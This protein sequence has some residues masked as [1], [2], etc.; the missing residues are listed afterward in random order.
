MQASLKKYFPIFVLPT[1]IAFSIAFVVPFIIG[2][3]LS[4]T[5][6]TTVTDAEFNGVQNYVDAFSKREGFV[7]SFGFTAL[8]VVVSVITVNVFAF[9]IAWILTRKL[10]GTNFFRT[11]FFMPNLIGGIVLGYTWQSMINAVLAKYSTTIIAD[12]K[13]GYVGL[14]VLINWQLV[15][16]MMI[17]YIAGLQNVPPELIEAAELDGATKWGVLRHVTIP[18]VMPSI[19]I[20][21]FLTFANTFKMFD[22]NLALTNGSP[23]HRTEMV[24]LNIVDTMFNRTGVEGVGQA[25]AVIFV[26]VVIV[27][28]LFQLRATR[29]R[30]VEA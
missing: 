2:F 29:S 3:L 6:F 15:G 16:Y 8:V 26:V 12:W 10:R 13:F 14:I 21:L 25:K 11:V 30:E 1:L 17:I 7:S 4:F 5:E 24:A 28:A 22:Q 20:C 9:S 18:M 19:T 23:R 27:F